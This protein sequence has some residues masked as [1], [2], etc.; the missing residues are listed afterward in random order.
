MRRVPLWL[1]LIVIGG[2]G[3]G[4]FEVGLRDRRLTHQR[5]RRLR[6]HAQRIGFRHHGQDEHREITAVLLVL[7][8]LDRPGE[9]GPV[10]EGGLSD[11][12]PATVFDFV[13]Q[14]DG[15]HPD[16]RVG[17]IL[18]FPTEWPTFEI[19]SHGM[20][21]LA[22]T[23]NA[24]AFSRSLLASELC[25]YLAAHRDWLFAFTGGHAF[26]S[27]RRG[28]GDDLARVL[29]VAEGIAARLPLEMITAWASAPEAE[30]RAS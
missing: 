6:A 30:R 13:E 28:D 11:G 27:A 18:H 17:V 9:V 1:W 12:T 19:G 16:P 2:L 23:G 25:V 3:Y 7:S 15:D 22:A 24:H 8:H 21:A 29:G 20:H 5:A 14:G 26:A 4:L 10:F